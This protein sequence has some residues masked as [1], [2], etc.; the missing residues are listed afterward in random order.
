MAKCVVCKAEN[1]EEEAA[2]HP[3][4][5]TTLTASLLRQ[6]ADRTSRKEQPQRFCPKHGGPPNQRVLV[7]TNATIT[8]NSETKEDYNHGTQQ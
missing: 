4:G 8:S 2:K 5:V 6:K 3:N 1:A 7:T